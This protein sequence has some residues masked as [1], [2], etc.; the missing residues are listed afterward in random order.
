M[1]WFSFIFEVRQLIN[2]I[3]RS[4]SSTTTNL[5]GVHQLTNTSRR[6]IEL[7]QSKSR[8]LSSHSK[9]S[10]GISCL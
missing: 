4:T 7:M 2:P 3:M 5:H 10:D 1:L 9:G 6:E 8:P